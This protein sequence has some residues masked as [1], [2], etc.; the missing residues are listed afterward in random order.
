[1]R[2]I[3]SFLR[4]GSR[5]L[6]IAGIAMASAAVVL[7]WRSA[8]IESAMLDRSQALSDSAMKQDRAGEAI[9][10]S[11]SGRP[12]APAVQQMLRRVDRA[13]NAAHVKIANVD[14]HPAAEKPDS[15]GRLELQL[16]GTGPYRDVK[17]L[18]ERM[19][20]SEPTLALDRISVTRAGGGEAAREVDVQLNFHVADL[21]TR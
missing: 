3:H 7:F 4:R 21:E 5:L 1:M 18:V 11:G 16:S 14:V 20:Q 9:G 19:L 10:A 8:V 13:A 2:S 15:P 6:V 17:N 12:L